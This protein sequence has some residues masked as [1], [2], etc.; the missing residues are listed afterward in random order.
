MIPCALTAQNQG[1]AKT[2]EG[3]LLPL[4]LCEEQCKT[5]NKRMVG[6]G[7]FRDGNYCPSFT[8]PSCCANSADIPG[9]FCFQTIVVL[10][11]QELLLSLQHIYCCKLRAFTWITAV[12]EQQMW[13]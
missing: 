5:A 6:K 4:D 9:F 3:A 13:I 8:F 1:R 2:A 10:Q 12:I 11:Q 7:S